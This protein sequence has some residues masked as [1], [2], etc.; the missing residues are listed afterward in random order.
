MA[1]PNTPGDGPASGDEQQLDISSEDQI[2]G[3]GQVPT[4]AMP[5]GG[6]RA[7]ETL[8]ADDYTAI[9]REAKD[10]W[11]LR[12]KQVSPALSLRDPYNPQPLASFEAFQD[13]P[14][15]EKQRTVTYELIALMDIQP[16]FYQMLEMRALYSMHSLGGG[17][18][19]I[20]AEVSIYW[21]NLRRQL[22]VI[23]DAWSLGKPRHAGTTP[24]TTTTTTTS[25]GGIG[26]HQVSLEITVARCLI[27]IIDYC[28]L[29]WSD[30][31]RFVR[32]V[33][34]AGGAAQAL[35][36]LICNITP[37]ATRVAGILLDVFPFLPQ[38]HKAAV[39]A[40][41]TE[42]LPI[43]GLDLRIRLLQALQSRRVLPQ[44]YLTAVSNM[45]DSKSTR[46]VAMLLLGS[47][48][49][50]GS[51]EWFKPTSILTKGV[52]L[53]D[54]SA[55]L[56][57]KL[58][59][60]ISHQMGTSN[61]VTGV[62]ALL[63]LPAANNI[64][65]TLKTVCG[66]FG[67]LSVPISPADLEQLW[68]LG[69]S[70]ATPYRQRLCAVL[71]LVMACAIRDL[72]ND[73]LTA[74]LTRLSK[75][76]FGNFFVFIT[77]YLRTNDMQALED[78]VS[79]MLGMDFTLPQD[80]LFMLKDAI[81]EPDSP[82]NDSVLARKLL[83]FPVA[84]AGGNN[85]YDINN[86]GSNSSRSALSF[87]GPDGHKVLRCVL[88]FIQNGIFQRSGINLQAWFVAIMLSPHPDSMAYYIQL[89]KSYV[90]ACF[91]SPCITPIPESVLHRIFSPYLEP[92][93]G[94]VAKEMPGA[95][96]PRDR[97]ADDDS[98]RVVTPSQI[99]GLLYVL[100]YNDQLMSSGSSSGQRESRGKAC[101]EYTDAF[102]DTLPVGHILKYIEQGPELH[103]Y[104]G[105]WSELLSL[106]VAQYPDQ[107]NP[108]TMMTE[109]FSA[110]R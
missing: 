21:A 89:I 41:F 11:A 108:A 60:I 2:L 73:V 20:N 24:A 30:L 31:E 17:G 44:C 49:R 98:V 77:A 87:D 63:S 61:D 47:A 29:P 33:I 80:R 48:F 52:P 14:I 106:A 54:I 27:A 79:G 5:S 70:A 55:T 85:D 59:D 7:P 9:E 99:L 93:N 104:Q 86:S 74:Q 1:Q 46:D 102:T 57:P 90:S 28:E 75:S 92:T 68:T 23:L 65:E 32:S 97:Q 19:Q 62:A 26:H 37:V 18:G 83:E 45:L 25:G 72:T 69:T 101:G 43:V 58:C 81:C 91:S 82:Y 51:L 8:D 110:S 100:Y 50:K 6:Q 96:P 105:V 12:A 34:L 42:C 22:P 107:M 38:V 40:V 95:T 84:A 109:S 66:Y 16:R 56:W 64:D 10:L 13:L 3:V 36:H 78:M 103:H 15:R 67:Y 35:A 71:F 88:R 94:P 39:M 4:G 53:G 76:S